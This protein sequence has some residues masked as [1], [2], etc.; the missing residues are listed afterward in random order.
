[1][2]RTAACCHAGHP[3][4][5]VLAIVTLV[6]PFNAS[7]GSK[8]TL[9]AL[10]GGNGSAPTALSVPLQIAFQGYLTD[11]SGSPITGSVSLAVTLWTASSGGTALWTESHSAVQT[12]SGVFAVALGSATPL[13]PGDFSGAPLFLGISVNGAAELPR[14]RLLAAPFAM[15]AAEADH[16]LTA[17]VATSDVWDLVDGAIHNTNQGNVGIGTTSPAAKLHVAGG[18][19]LVNNGHPISSQL[20]GDP[21]YGSA[22]LVDDH[23][24]TYLD[25]RGDGPGKDFFLRTYATGWSTRLTVLN[26]GRVGI[27]TQQPVGRLHVSGGALLVDNGNP[28]HVQLAGNPG[29]GS[30]IFVDGNDDT[31]LDARG[32][33]PGKDLHVRTYAGGWN[34]RLSVTNNG[35]VGI[36]TTTPSDRLTVQGVV[37]STIGGFRYPD[38]SL[39]TTAQLFGP[40][41][42]QGPIGPQ[43]PEGP[44]G[45]AGPAGG[46]PGPPGPVG[47]IGPAGPAGPVGAAGPVGPAG[48]LGP[49]GPRGPAGPA[50]P[51]GP[52]VSTSAMCNTASGCQAGATLGCDAVCSGRVVAAMCG[53]CTATSDTGSCQTFIS[54]ALCCVCAP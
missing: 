18:G 44:T 48:P 52:A 6:A 54:N 14:T 28:M 32:D 7:A 9:G 11:D 8:G 10:R 47:P 12:T 40:P 21:G 30:G 35:N 29:Y 17:D 41:G 13:N 19:V 3:L 4:I 31:Y 50:G 38:G 24:D 2:N 15:R 5:V 20:V 43:G 42:P 1:M 25:A 27:G 36:G 49:V 45:P 33:G 34:T 51:Q 22:L 23:D 46:P 39:Q 16:A 37:Q 53:P 26:D